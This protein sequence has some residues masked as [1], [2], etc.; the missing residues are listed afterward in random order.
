VNTL[1][2]LFFFFFFFFA[3]SD[4]LKLTLS[5]SDPL[6]L[7]LYR[8]SSHFL[9]CRRQ[10]IIGNLRKLG[11]FSNSTRKREVKEIRLVSK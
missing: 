9:R 4:L 2:I 6:K 1:L 8:C 10:K 11:I 5:S 7:T 3:D